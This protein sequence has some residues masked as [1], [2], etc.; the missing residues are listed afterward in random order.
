MS[1][2]VEFKVIISKNGDDADVQ[3]RERSKECWF[4]TV[5]ERFTAIGLLSKFSFKRMF[6]TY[7]RIEVIH[8]WN[9]F[10]ADHHLMG[11]FA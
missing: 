5:W 3:T 4:S 1:A 11:S 6:L 2:C 7:Q 10:C 8:Q 9:S